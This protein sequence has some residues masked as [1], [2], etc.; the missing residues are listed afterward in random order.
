MGRCSLHVRRNLVSS[1]AAVK[2]EIWSRE[3]GADHGNLSG[4]EEP[5][6]FCWRTRLIRHVQT[7]VFPLVRQWCSYSQAEDLI[8]YLVLV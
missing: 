5:R 2:E 1:F 4:K 3:S 8:P 6:A 7:F